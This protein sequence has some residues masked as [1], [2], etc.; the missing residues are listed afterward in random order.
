MKP[1]TRKP[2]FPLHITEEAREL[3]LILLTFLEGWF[4]SY[5]STHDRLPYP[6]GTCTPQWMITGST[7]MA[8]V[9][10]LAWLAVLAFDPKDQQ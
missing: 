9:L 7:F 6:V 4:V 1:H 2:L 5:A 10:P 8:A 3:L